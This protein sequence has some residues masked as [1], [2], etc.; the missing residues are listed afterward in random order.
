MAMPRYEATI[1]YAPASYSLAQSYAR[2]QNE[3][4][5]RSNYTSTTLTDYQSSFNATPLFTEGLKFED[6]DTDTNANGTPAKVEYNFSDNKQPQLT[7]RLYSL[8]FY[9]QSKTA[10]NDKMGSID[11][12]R[13]REE[14]GNIVNKQQLSQLIQRELL[15]LQL[16]VHHV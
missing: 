8:P 5:A 7:S 4:I 9:Y 13:G 12:M 3:S 14:N 16:Q 2:S 15:N 1:A 6:S 11:T 10:I